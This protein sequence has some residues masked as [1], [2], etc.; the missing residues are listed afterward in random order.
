MLFTT[1][2]TLLLN[3]LGW[4]LLLR[5]G[6]HAVTLHCHDWSL[7]L[8]W[9]FFH[10]LFSPALSLRERARF[11]L[12]PLLRHFYRRRHCFAFATCQLRLLNRDCCLLA[13]PR[14]CRLRLLMP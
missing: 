8:Y 2:I 5:L 7:P 10:A 12:P 14:F 9:A 11:L 4:G 1:D 3:I 13:M 6:L